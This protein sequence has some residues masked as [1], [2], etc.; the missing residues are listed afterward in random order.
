MQK[1][2]LAAACVFLTTPL[3]AQT[4]E[5]DGANDSYGLKTELAERV[6]LKYHKAIDAEE[7]CNK[8][9][10]SPSDSQA[11][12]ETI[13]GRMVANSPDVAVGAARLLTLNAVANDQTAA[14]ISDEGCDGDRVKKLLAFFDQRLAGNVSASVSAAAGPEP[15]TDQGP[16]RQGQ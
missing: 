3:F 8:R 7:K 1:I 9:Q 4:V 16:A 15:L 11:M 10:F 14:L 2:L 6:F 13:A 12:E 5:Q